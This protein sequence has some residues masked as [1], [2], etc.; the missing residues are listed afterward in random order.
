MLKCFPVKS[1]KLIR[2]QIG[3]MGTGVIMQK[4]D[5]ARQH[6]RAFRLYGVS[7]HLQPPRN[8][9]HLSVF[10]CLRPF[11]MLDEHTLH[12]AHLQSNK[13]TTVR[14]CAFSLCMFP[15]LQMAVS[16]S[17]NSVASF[18]EE[19]VLWRVFDFH[20][21]A[22]HTCML[23]Y[24]LPTVSGVCTSQA[25]ALKEIVILLPTVRILIYYL[26]YLISLWAGALKVCTWD[27]A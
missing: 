13:E 23:R 21:T 10:L 27:N 11:A 12:Y 25:P 7:Q 15:T 24:T 17:N 22:P 9:P 20:L 4:D 5:T 6:S 19:Y 18:C 14:N 8:E 2:H 26:V 16:I 3:S 1:F